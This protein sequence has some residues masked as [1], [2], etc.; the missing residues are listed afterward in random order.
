M[1]DEHNIVT[2]PSATPHTSIANLHLQDTTLSLQATGLY[3]LLCTFPPNWIIRRNDLVNRKTNG[4][5]SIQ[6]A[7]NELKEQN[8]LTVTKHRNDD[9][10]FQKPFYTFF[11]SKNVNPCFSSTSLHKSRN[12]FVD[13]LYTTT[14]TLEE[15]RGLQLV[16]ENKV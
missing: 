13:V 5:A 8:F 12:R 6:R 3:A 15:A 10:T 9:G 11:P 1:S 4:K 2:A 16:D 7:I 14:P